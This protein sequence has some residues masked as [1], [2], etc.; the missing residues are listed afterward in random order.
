MYLININS[1][2]LIKKIKML[3]KWHTAIVKSIG[4]LHFR[5]GNGVHQYHT[6]LP[7][8]GEV[9]HPE[10]LISKFNWVKILVWDIRDPVRIGDEYLG[11]L[12]GGY[13]CY[14]ANEDIKRKLSTKEKGAF[15]FKFSFSLFTPLEQEASKTLFEKVDHLPVLYVGH[16]F[17]TKNVQN[18]IL[19]WM[20]S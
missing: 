7:S 2:L 19:S 14:V 12:A 4:T 5:E 9:Q 16:K 3:L 13:L 20:I 18:L 6:R 10:L 17:L 1:Y 15:S 11:P 8:L